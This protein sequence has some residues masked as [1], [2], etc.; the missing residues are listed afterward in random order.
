[1]VLSWD[2]G[3]LRLAGVKLEAIQNWR[4]EIL[5]NFLVVRERHFI[6]DRCTR[7]L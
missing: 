7:S 2:A 3:G 4:T 1:M 6:L 5:K